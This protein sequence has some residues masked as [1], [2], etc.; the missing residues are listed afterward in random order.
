M[1][2]AWGTGGSDLKGVLNDTDDFFSEE[3]EEDKNRIADTQREFSQR[4]EAAV[5]RQEQDLRHNEKIGFLVLEAATP[6]RLSVSYY[7]EFA[8]VQLNRLTGGITAGLMQ[9]KRS[10]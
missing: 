5:L 8:P 1:L 10:G 9:I 4:L 6:G 2:V 3:D 7:Q